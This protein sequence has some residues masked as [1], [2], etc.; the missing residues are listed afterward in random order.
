M[1]GEKKSETRDA[2]LETIYGPIRVLNVSFTWNY[3]CDC[4]LPRRG[5]VEKGNASAEQFSDFES[6]EVIA[7]SSN[8]SSS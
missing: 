5:V 2:L 6:V 7:C 8:T 1:F 3:I 4:R